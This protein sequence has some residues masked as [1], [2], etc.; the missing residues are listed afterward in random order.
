M[1]YT[2]NLGGTLVLFIAKGSGPAPLLGA[3]LAPLNNGRDF[4]HRQK[5]S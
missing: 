4:V 3:N 1:K 5:R 2:G